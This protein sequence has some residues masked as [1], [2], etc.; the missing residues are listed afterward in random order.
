MPAG[1][2]F[3]PENYIDRE[4]LFSLIHTDVK[5]TAGN[6]N[7]AFNANDKISRKEKAALNT[8][9]NIWRHYRI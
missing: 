2:S 8:G 9:G 7:F 1:E 5:K 4:T 3:A 6:T